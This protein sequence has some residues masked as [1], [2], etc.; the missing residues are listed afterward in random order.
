M[1]GDGGTTVGATGDRD[2]VP[3]GLAATQKGRT[4]GFG[5]RLEPIP[6]FRRKMIGYTGV[7]SPS[8]RPSA[9]FAPGR[10]RVQA[11]DFFPVDS[12]RFGVK[13]PR[14]RVSRRDLLRLRRV[15]ASLSKL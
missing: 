13:P 2:R 6:P 1:V 7:N 10:P 5:S 14:S 11:S 15:G 8:V 9:V 12:S 3:G 4:P